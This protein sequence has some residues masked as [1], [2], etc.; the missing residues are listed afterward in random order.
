MKFKIKVEGEI[1][2][3]KIRRAKM[4]WD[5]C[6]EENVMKGFRSNYCLG[7]L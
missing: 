5:V 6:S 3:V 2:S 1:K 4:N 7:L